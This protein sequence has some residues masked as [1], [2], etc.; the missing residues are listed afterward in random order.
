M[1]LVTQAVRPCNLNFKCSQP[2]CSFL[3]CDDGGEGF[4]GLSLLQYMFKGNYKSMFACLWR[5]CRKICCPTN[6]SLL[7]LTQF[8]IL[9]LLYAWLQQ[10]LPS[11]LSS[12]YFCSQE[13][14]LGLWKG[15]ALSSL[16]L[17]RSLPSLWASSLELQK[18]QGLVWKGFFTWCF[19]LSFNRGLSP[20]NPQDYTGGLEW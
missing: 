14:L 1:V 13:L 10:Q 18:P 6:S 2:D 11:G 9:W 16:T 5:F 8:T 19:Q 15:S 12:K 20:T 3:P 4:E 7:S 17:H